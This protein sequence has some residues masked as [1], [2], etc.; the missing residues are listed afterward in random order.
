MPKIF[1]HKF[2]H[3]ELSQFSANEYIEYSCM[4]IYAYSC[5]KL[6]SNRPGAVLK[7]KKSMFKSGTSRG[8]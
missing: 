2:L 4:N 6:L 3:F 8:V 7:Q 5:F 1:F